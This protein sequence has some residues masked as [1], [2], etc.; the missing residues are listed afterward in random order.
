MFEDEDAFG[1][2]DVLLEYEVGYLWQFLQRVGRVGKDKVKLLAARLDESEHIT[3]DRGAYI[4]AELLK[5]LGYESMVVAVGLYTH[6][7]CT[8]SR[9]EFEGY[10]ACAREE[11]EGIYT[12]KVDIAIEHIEDI[13]LGKVCCGSGLERTRHIEVATLVL[14]CNYTHIFLFLN[15]VMRGSYE[16]KL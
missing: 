8:A 11:V 15:G 14:S 6:Y 2:K 12:V 1:S 5:A 13:L 9:H 16:G 3:T 4:G 10:A 7:A